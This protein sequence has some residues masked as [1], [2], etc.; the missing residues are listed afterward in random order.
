MEIWTAFSSTFPLPSFASMF[1]K[2]TE[3]VVFRNQMCSIFS[4]LVDYFGSLLWTGAIYAVA[5]GLFTD[6]FSR[7]LNRP[8]MEA[9]IIVVSVL[10]LFYHILGLGTVHF[11]LS[12]KLPMLLL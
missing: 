9:K 7:R 6:I 5:N 8:F 4:E 10:I 3:V 2:T 11:L 1:K 12:V